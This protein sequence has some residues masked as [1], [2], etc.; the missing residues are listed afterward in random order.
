MASYTDAK[1][2]P[3]DA[4]V[5]RMETARAGL[6]SL[7]DTQQ[8]TEKFLASVIDNL[9]HVRERLIGHENSDRPAPGIGGT[10]R[11]SGLVPDAGMLLGRAALAA[12]L[13]AQL[14]GIVG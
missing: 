2:D 9:S 13:S 14:R 7:S 5:G 4:R 6:P 8:E 10:P 1:E 11:P 3:R 12:E